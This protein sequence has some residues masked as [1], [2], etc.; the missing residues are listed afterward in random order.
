MDEPVLETQALTKRY[1]S[2]LAVDGLSIQITRGGVFGLLGPNGSGK[3]TTMSLLPGNFVF[4][5][6]VMALSSWRSDGPRAAPV[7]G[8]LL[9]GSRIERL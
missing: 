8:L 6:I 1:R 3:T 2:V 4:G 5:A 7:T 9:D